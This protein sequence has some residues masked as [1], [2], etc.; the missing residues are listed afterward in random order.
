MPVSELG[1]LLAN[2]HL[3]AVGLFGRMEHPSEGRLVNVGFPVRF[4]AVPPEPDRPAPPLG[5][6]NAALLGRGKGAV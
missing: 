5:A 3:A 4:S 1:E 2:E 6:D